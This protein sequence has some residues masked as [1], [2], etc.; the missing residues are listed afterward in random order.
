MRPKA[1]NKMTITDMNIHWKIFY[2]LILGL[3]VAFV[4]SDPEVYYLYNNGILMSEAVR[5]L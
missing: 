1:A 3:I 2:L 5:V 4:S